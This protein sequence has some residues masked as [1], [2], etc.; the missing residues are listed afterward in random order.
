MKKC[1]WNSRYREGRVGMS[2][3]K[4]EEVSRLSAS[5][6]GCWSEHAHSSS[7]AFSK[8]CHKFGCTKFWRS[9]FTP[10]FLHSWLFSRR[11]P[12][13]WPVFN[14]WSPGC[15]A[16]GKTYP[17]SHTL[18]SG[19]W[20]QARLC[21]SYVE[22]RPLPLCMRTYAQYLTTGRCTDDHSIAINKTWDCRSSV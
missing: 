6:A 13:L 17:P 2:E 16:S 18:L 9:S 4:G 14:V 7:H 12:S 19:C 5:S 1:I 11:F 15:A 10:L 20:W 3:S 22:T 8:K 21:I